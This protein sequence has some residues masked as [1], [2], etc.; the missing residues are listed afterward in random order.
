MSVNKFLALGRIGKKELKHTPQGDA[1]CT[2]SLALSEKYKG[3]EKTEWIQCVA[4]KDKAENIDK[5]FSVGSEIFIDAKVQ[6]RNYEKDGITRYV[7]E[8]IVFNFSFTG[9]SKVENQN[10]NNQSSQ[11][12]WG[13][14][15]NQPA[16]QQNQQGQ[17]G[18]FN[19]PQ[20]TNGS[21]HPPG[22]QCQDCE[23]IPF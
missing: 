14:N 22:C 15:Q 21:Q 9:G 10:Q 1:V 6:T 3:E 11:G 8:F 2:F 4:W 17:S 23:D 12:S 19:Q 16:A 20:N 18:N 5:Y 13:A 7:T